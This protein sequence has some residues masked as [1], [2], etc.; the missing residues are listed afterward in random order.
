M[1]RNDPFRGYT[2]TGV[3]VLSHDAIDWDAEQLLRK[4]CPDLYA[5]WQ[6]VDVDYMLEFVFK[7]TPYIIPLTHCGLIFGRTIFLNTK[8]VPIYDMQKQEADITYASARTVML[9]PLLLEDGNENLY[10]STVMHECGHLRYH[11]RY[12]TD[13]RNYQTGG[14]CWTNCGRQYISDDIPDTGKLLV[15]DSDWLEHQAQYFASAIL[16]P[17]SIVIKTVF[18]SSHI[19]ALGHCYTK[20]IANRYLV[21]LISQTFQVS[22]LAARIRLQQFGLYLDE[23]SEWDSE[24]NPLPRSLYMT[25]LLERQPGAENLTEKKTRRRKKPAMSWLDIETLKDP[26]AAA[27]FEQFPTPQAEALK[28]QMNKKRRK[29]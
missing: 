21:N 6:P 5:E 13:P 12:F 2:I 29:K 16:M 25:E 8:N 4:Y 1:N 17:R 14:G 19:N 26:A 27:F 15:S 24:N 11:E 3:P 28:K 20:E 10:R 7:G 9:D 18:D 23:E 22:K